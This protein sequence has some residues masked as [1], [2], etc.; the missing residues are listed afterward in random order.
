MSCHPKISIPKLCRWC[1]AVAALAQPTLHAQVNLDPSWRVGA[2]DTSKPGF[3]WNFF[4][5]PPNRGNSSSRA[6]ADLAGLSL[7]GTT[8]EPLANIGDPTTV[9]PAIGQAQPANPAS[10]VLRF[11][12]P[13]VIN[14]SK[15]EGDSKGNFTPD[16]Q[17]PG[18]NLSESTDGQA[19]EI[20]TYL[21]LPAGTI[22]MGV[23][24][25]DG[26]QAFAGPNPADIFGR[27]G[28]G[29]F[30]GGRGASD[31]TFTVV[32]QQA[33]TYPFRTI[34][35][36]GG[37]DS[38]IEWFTV[39][40]DG[41]KVLI[42]DVAGGGIP[43]FRALAASASAPPY[44]KVAS[45]LPVPRQL[46]ST[47]PEVTLVIVDGTTKVDDASVTLQV[48]G[49]A[50][51]LTKKRQ[52]SSLTVS[53]GVLPGLHLP[54]EKHTGM[55]TYKDASGSYSRTQEWTFYNLENLILPDQPVAGENFNSYPEA[56]SQATTVPPGWVAT[57]YTYKETEGWD[58]N[59]ISSDAYLDW[60]LISTD[61]VLEREKEVMDNNKSQLLNGKPVTNWMTGN[62]I[63]VASDGRKRNISDPDGGPNISVGQIQIVVSAPFNLSSAANPVL[64]FHSG[65][66]LSGN[67]EQM[68][69]EYS[70]DK[71]ATWLPVI[72]MR[73]STTVKLLPDGSYDVL[74]MSTNMDTEITKWPDPVTGP[75]GGNFGDMIAAPISQDLAP[76]FAN[77]N[78]GVAARRIEAVRIPQASKQGDVRLRLT[79]A[80]S[81]GWEWGVDNIAFYDIAPAQSDA[82]KIS[83][84]SVASGSITVKWSNGGTLES[85]A[86]ATGGTWTSTGNSSGTFSEAVPATGAK[87][88]RVRR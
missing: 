2:V 49:S 46:D 5:A 22:T 47:S 48:D 39:K 17:M 65:A 62:L 6:E 44:V 69:M 57:N 41:S 35:E 1:L 26:F 70:I 83:N 42:N 9:G 20:L 27:V 28:I 54:A 66:R 58:L 30:E 72:Y 29:I 86:S 85:S 37:G 77:R 74:G 50:V 34:W 4:S 61:T 36:N 55:L 8:G 63:F 10:S 19:A 87:F 13:T 67:K 18:V 3:I 38:N 76:Y 45:P 51:P 60:V 32:V 33:G 71:G 31:T 25:D 40:E 53:T 79:H 84:V 75:K 78:D 12:I 14:V 24:S 15:V 88:Y 73:N 81:C 21:T 59:D 56:S 82:P 23:N 52:G 16:D 43:A 64:T 11:E 68:T 7:D 80:G